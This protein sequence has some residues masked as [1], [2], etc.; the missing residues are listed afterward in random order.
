M[1]LPWTGDGVPPGDRALW[2]SAA[3]F[4]SFHVQ[5]VGVV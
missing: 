2:P 4:L 3:N 5:L 1:L